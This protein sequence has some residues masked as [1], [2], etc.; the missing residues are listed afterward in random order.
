L[1]I[2]VRS[3][4]RQAGAGRR[5]I[6][7]FVRDAVAAGVP[8]VHLHTMRPLD[9]HP[10]FESVGFRKL[11]SQAFSAFAYLGEPA[12]RY[13][14]Y[15]MTLD[16][17]RAPQPATFFQ[18]ICDVLEVDEAIRR[19]DSAVFWPGSPESNQIIAQALSDRANQVPNPAVEIEYELDRHGQLA[20]YV[21]HRREPADTAAFPEDLFVDLLAV[22]PD[23]E[24]TGAGT[25]LMRQIFEKARQREHHAVYLYC[26]P[27]NR[28]ACSFYDA[29]QDRPAVSGLVQMT[30]RFRSSNK[31][32]L[33]IYRFVLSPEEETIGTPYDRRIELLDQKWRFPASLR[34]A[35]RAT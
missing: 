15:G 34:A 33:D 2:N 3:G 30:Q 22:H 32:D 24:P 25:R 7:A 10:F 18:L 23:H 1:H 9:F 26:H 29:L 28:N 35:L 14:T 6:A 21:L 20:G 27:A 5:L 17:R 31:P 4:F 13:I 11:H 16:D 8:G 12:L 19:T